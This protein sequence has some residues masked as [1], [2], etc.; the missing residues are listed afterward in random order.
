MKQFYQFKIRNHTK[1][2]TELHVIPL[3]ENQVQNYLN[4]V[5]NDPLSN[6]TAVL[7]KAL[8]KEEAALA[9]IKIAR[10]CVEESTPQGYMETGN[11]E[12]L[13]KIIENF[14]NSYNI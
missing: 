12:I 14:E 1:R 9:V 3:E 8:N 13:D 7:D 5:N 4:S 6:M 11:L 2:V 10:H